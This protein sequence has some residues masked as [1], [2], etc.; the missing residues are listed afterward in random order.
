MFRDTKVCDSLEVASMRTSEF[1]LLESG[2]LYFP[3]GL[4]SKKGGERDDGE[5][6]VNG[7][8]LSVSVLPEEFC[9]DNAKVEPTQDQVSCC[10]KNFH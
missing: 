10:K 7:R 5:G 1:Y 6:L 8:Q 4:R 9:I 3:G 2:E